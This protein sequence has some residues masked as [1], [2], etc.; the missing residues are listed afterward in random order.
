MWVRTAAGDAVAAGVVYAERASVSAPA[1]GDANA[2]G[3]SAGAPGAARVT[4]AGVT[5]SGSPVDPTPGLVP[6]AWH[7][8]CAVRASAVSGVQLYLN[9]DDAGAVDV[10]PPATAASYG[11]VAGGSFVGALDDVW[12]LGRA[13]SP[14]EVTRLHAA[15]SFAARLDGTSGAYHLTDSTGSSFR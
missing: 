12:A 4:F 3:V 2:L 5:P 7:F 15:R 10:A 9:G 14:A 1:A 6:D 13:M 8:V 11:V